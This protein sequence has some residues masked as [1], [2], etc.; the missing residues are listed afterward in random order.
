M[1]VERLL[2]LVPEDQTWATR[3]RNYLLLV[4][5]THDGGHVA[6]LDS[7]RCKTHEPIRLDWHLVHDAQAL[8]ERVLGHACRLQ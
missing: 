8:S 6:L 5:H 3:T 7:G 2:L 1:V 4:V